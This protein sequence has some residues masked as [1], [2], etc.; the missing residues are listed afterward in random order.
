V[1]IGPALEEDRT[2][3][4]GTAAHITAADEDGPR[5]DKTLTSEERRSPSNG[6]WLCAICGRLIDTDKN[7]FTADLLRKWKAESEARAFKAIATS[8]P[9]EPAAVVPAFVADDDD[10]EF[11]N[12]LGLPAEDSAD[13]VS[14]R[15]SRATINDIAA[16]RGA[17]DWPSY[18]I[19]LTLTLGGDKTESISLDGIVKAL[20][21]AD[22]LSLVSPPGTGKSTTVV[23]LA[24]HIAAAGHHVPVIVPLGE[25]SDRSDDFFDFAVRRHSFGAFRRQHFMQLAYHGR[26]VLLLDGW[27]E[28]D[29]ESRKRALGDLAAFRRDY[30]QLAVVVGTRRHA[31]PIGGDII[32]IEPLSTEQQLAIARAQRGSEG[33]ALVDVAIRTPGVRELL[34][35]PLYLNALLAMPSGS[36]FPTTKEEVLRMFV[37]THEAKQKNAEILRNEL[38]GFHKDMLI[39]LA[40][41]AI[42]TANTSIQE[43]SAYQAITGVEKRLSTEGLLTI[44]PQPTKVI[45]VLVGSHIMVRQGA[46]ALMFQHQQFQE[47]Y[48]SYEVERVMTE[49]ARG[50]TSARQ[51][52]CEDV[53]NWPSWEESI[54]FACERLSRENADGVNAVAEAILEA[55]GIDPILSADMIFRSSPEVW[56]RIKDRVV[57]FIERWHTPGK[58]DR[59]VRFMITSG[60]PEFAGKVWPLVSH[61]DNQIHLRV[62]RTADRFRPD[63]LGEDREERLAALGEKTR[64]HVISEIAGNSGYDG[65]ELA[66]RLAKRDPSPKVVASVLQSLAFRRGDRHVV[67][68]L[69]S[70]PDAV[71]EQVARKGYP[72][73]IAD[74]GLQQ[75]LEY[76]RKA[77]AARPREP[78]SEVNFLSAP[79]NR[80]QGAAER[81]DELIRSS[82]FPIKD[83]HADFAI[84][85]AYEAYP[86]Q[87]ADA[88]IGRIADGLEV[89]YDSHEYLDRAPSLDEGPIPEAV[90]NPATPERLR[91]AAAYVIGPKT[92]VMLMDELL[93][94][95]EEYSAQDWRVDQASRDKYH[96]IKD[97]I[98]ATRRGSFLAALFERAA[99]DN[100]RHIAIMANLIIRHGKGDREE[101]D[102][103]ESIRAQLI[104]VFH[105]WIDV[106]LKSQHGTRHQMSAVVWA[107]HRFSDA[108][109]VP[110]LK[111]MLDR[112]LTDWKRARETHRRGQ[113]GGVPADASHSYT[114]AYRDAFAAI[115]GDEVVKLMT[116]YL[117]NPEFGVDAAAVLASLWNR[118]HPSGKER[119]LFGRDY[120]EVEERRA[121]RQA[122][123]P[124]PTCD[125]AQVIFATA[126]KIATEAKDDDDRRHAIALAQVALGI[127]HGSK[128][129]E[130]D[131]LLKLPL[132]Y[133]S[134]QSLLTA[135]V[136]AGEIV[137]AD[138]LVAAVRELVEVAQSQSWRLDENR[139][140]LMGW[141]ELFPFSTRP[142]AVFEAI[143]L[144]PANRRRDP[145]DFRRLLETL[146]QGTHPD[147]LAVLEEMARRDPRYLKMYE[148]WDAL[149]KIGSEAAAVVFLDR[150]CSAAERGERQGFDSFRVAD[151]LGLLGKKFFS[152]RAEMLKRY[153][154]A[155]AKPV[156]GIL[157]ASLANIA[158]DEI[159]LAMIAKQATDGR[160]FRQ[161]ALSGAIRDVAVGRQTVDETS[162]AFQEFS[163]PLNALRKELFA[164]VLA[165]NEQSAL[166]EASL[167]YID[168]LRDEHGRIG[169][170]PRHPDIQTGRVWPTQAAT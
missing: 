19:E 161:G 120:S 118:A 146:R 34:A 110:K 30:P 42:R 95:N 78:V 71:W 86:T 89:P 134:K 144:L 93:T 20:T 137:Q 55:L 119:S 64:R 35:I 97:A 18:V 3:N 151:R 41:Q 136:R 9:E 16:F 36:P 11:L 143:D 142:M 70:A 59:A 109:F 147:T 50:N 90:L 163:V 72:D 132:P 47:W 6:I 83:Q 5:Y 17:R 116:D 54:L 51:I 126:S 152:L 167:T 44:Q 43:A 112:D 24:E 108:S 145:S 104:S 159:I 96:S 122:G 168:K 121:Q 33:E 88:I 84:Q 62:L 102:V 22:G 4:V 75:R 156:Q 155:A 8:S 160:T 113:P 48:G 76:L 87:V 140:E 26:L 2:S 77:E 98:L 115:G 21:A 69:R 170:E 103:S 123:K 60:R 73:E 128:R 38:H 1:T 29:P 61:D 158:D 162:G 46:G 14:A 139:G 138:D 165:G 101:F 106:L 40:V 68:I 114:N 130:I 107:M 125:H 164:R 124:M 57:P 15:M 23:Q 7:R 49:A 154:S 82:D 92:I 80:P 85:R 150:V 53:L 28:L 81:I 148:W 13:A 129:T 37:M 166:A 25:W 157:E 127:P 141:I 12:T 149:A 56:A 94:L 67:D 31:L 66:V 169:D 153:T 58:I 91:N 65:M 100:P 135:A 27:N 10:R 131:E 79:E 111:L 117:P 52:L 133:A 99:T 45:D 39:G 105:A 74:P 63:V 32:A